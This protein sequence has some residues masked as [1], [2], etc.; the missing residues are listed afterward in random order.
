MD[1]L[2]LT[3]PSCALCDHAKEVLARLSAEFPVKVATMDLGS[4]EGRALAERGGLLF[5]PGVLVDGDAFSYGRLSE[6]KLRK[7]IERRLG[8][9]RDA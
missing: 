2:L 3:Q 9:K 5:P 6:R 1:I 7:E 4:P 8:T